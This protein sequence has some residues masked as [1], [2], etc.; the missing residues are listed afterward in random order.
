MFPFAVTSEHSHPSLYGTHH[1][2]HMEAI[3]SVSG[4]VPM[5][6]MSEPPDQKPN[7]NSGSSTPYLNLSAS[8]YINPPSLLSAQV[9]RIDDWIGE[10][11]GRGN[12]RS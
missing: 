12:V 8:S 4:T 6:P 9:C 11:G 2:H 5:G 7:V 3:T 10:R 1:Q